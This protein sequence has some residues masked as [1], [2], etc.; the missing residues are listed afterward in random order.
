MCFCF[1]RSSYWL[2]YETL[3]CWDLLL[4]FHMLVV[5]VYSLLCFLQQNPS[6]SVC[7]VEILYLHRQKKVLRS[8]GHES[9]FPVTDLLHQEIFCRYRLTCQKEKFQ[10]FYVSVLIRFLLSTAI[11]ASGVLFF[12]S[13]ASHIISFVSLLLFLFLLETTEK[14]LTA[15]LYDGCFRE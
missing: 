12:I 8:I 7:T 6:I 10:R 13:T 2:M 3:L 11:S 1:P 4:L 9:Y 15:A 5:L 14:N